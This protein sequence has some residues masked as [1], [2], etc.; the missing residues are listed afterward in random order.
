MIGTDSHGGWI[1]KHHKTNKWIAF[2]QVREGRSYAW[3]GIVAGVRQRHI[4]VFD[5][6]PRG[7]FEE[8]K[9]WSDYCA[10]EWI[11]GATWL[12]PSEIKT[13]NE[14][15]VEHVF[16]EMQMFPDEEQLLVS[17]FE[18]VPT[19]DTRMEH[20]YMNLEYGCKPVHWAGTIRDFIGEDANFEECVKYVIAFDS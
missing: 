4:Y 15:Y 3:F 18:E 17:D 20:I 10:G 6:P 13:A 1:A 8:A 12:K 5:F 14:A 7:I 19:P 11:H 16:N 9:H 2:R